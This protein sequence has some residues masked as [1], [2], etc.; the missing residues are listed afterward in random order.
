MRC[1]TG[2]NNGIPSLSAQ[3]FSKS[4]QMPVVALLKFLPKKK[5]NV[6]QKTKQTD[7]KMR[8]AW[9]PDD[10]YTHLTRLDPVDLVSI[11]CLKVVMFEGCFYF[12]RK[13]NSSHTGQ[14]SF[15]TTNIPHH[16][17]HSPTKQKINADKSQPV[18]ACFTIFNFFAIS[19][20]VID[21]HSDPSADPSPA[22]SP[23]PPQSHVPD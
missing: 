15:A 22:T 21:S 11:Q 9:I 4:L 17:R 7:F 3:H 16:T 1:K 2:M 13:N 8:V 5:N 20:R 14:N 6:T 18:S 10:Q 23:C 19:V 12:N